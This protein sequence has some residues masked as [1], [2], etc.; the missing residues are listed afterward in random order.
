MFYRALADPEAERVRREKR[1][2]AGWYF[3]G[4]EADHPV[5][6]GRLATK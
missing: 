1:E 6:T 2:A 3:H 5:L 4:D